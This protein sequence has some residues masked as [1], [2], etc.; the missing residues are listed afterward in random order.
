[1][2]LLWA[3]ILFGLLIFFHELGHFILAKAVGV[4]VL[5]FSIGF[6]PKIISKQIGETEYILS[7]FPLG[8]YVK[9]L[10]E[11]PD[12]EIAAEDIP[13]AFNNQSVWK[14]AAIVV[15]GP[16]FNLILSYVIFVVFLSFSLPVVIPVLNDLTNTKIEGIRKDS[17]AM[18]AGLM[19]DDIVLS[20]N[21][22]EIS[23]WV[24]M[25]EVLI[26]SPGKEVSLSVRRGGKLLD[27]ALVP[28]PRTV[29]ARSG[30]EEVLGD[31]GISRLSTR[32]EGVINDSP[33]MEAGLLEGDAIITVDGQYVGDWAE[34]AEFINGSPEKALK[35]EVKR[36]NDTIKLNVTP[37]AAG[38]IG[39]SKS[40]GFDVIQ[41]DSILLAPV[42]GAQAVYGWTVLTLDVAKRLITGNMSTKMLG[43]P[44]VIVNEASK[45]ASSGM[46]DYFYLIAVIS[47]NLAIINLFPVPVLDGGHL[48]F[49]GIEAV[50]GKPL[51]DKVME[52]LTKIGFGLLMMLIALVLYNDTMKVIVPWVQKMI[53]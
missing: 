45:A 30:K 27:I 16:I 5:K 36:G 13:R 3:V 50:R 31:S 28:E 47:I 22:N 23:T 18:D 53:G 41:T 12:D 14:R 43:G 49:M 17:P 24:E 20:V 15:A 46:A 52:I 38:K 39:I 35:L 6:G 29:T 10:G 40:M 37:D 25:D 44:I 19:I 2:T 4:K 48:V 33:A 1:M 21:G 9:P 11:D 34:M 7:A 26:K 32:I 8:G 51:S 42:K